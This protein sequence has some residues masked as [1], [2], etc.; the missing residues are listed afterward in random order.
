MV[1]LRKIV[2]QFDAFGKARTTLETSLLTDQ[3]YTNHQSA[4][5]PKDVAKFEKHAEYIRHLFENR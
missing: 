1:K 5:S 2:I 3:K 4:L